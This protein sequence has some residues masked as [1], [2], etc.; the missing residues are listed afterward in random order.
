MASSMLLFFLASLLVNVTASLPPDYT[1]VS[2][3]VVVIGGGSS[4][5]YAAVNLLAH[6]R[7]VAVL[8]Q[9]GRL[10]GHVE[11][12]IDPAT[13]APSNIGV[14]DFYNNSIN[15]AYFSLLGVP[16]APVP[17]TATGEVYLDLATGETVPKFDAEAQIDSFLPAVLAYAAYVN[18]TY[19]YLTLSYENLSYPIPDELLEPFTVFAARHNFTAMLQFYESLTQNIG[20]LWQ[21]PTYHGIHALDPKLVEFTFVGFINA[22]SGNNQ[23]I[24]TAAATYLGAQNVFLNSTVLGVDRS[25]G[26]FGLEEGG[27]DTSDVCVLSTSPSSS[28]NQTTL[29]KARKLLVAIPPT[30]ASLAS[31]HIDLD[32]QER[33]VFSKFHG[34][35]YGVTV[36]AHPGLNTSNTYTNI[37]A[38]TPDNLP[39]LPGAFSYQP[40]PSAPG[41][42]AAWFGALAE[43]GWTDAD[44]EGLIRGEIAR[45][46]AN[47][48]AAGDPADVVFDFLKIH[49]PF[50][51]SA[52]PHDVADGF[53]KELYALE[54]RRNTFWTGAAWSEQDSSQIWWWSELSLL[55]KIEAALN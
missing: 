2:R 29:V 45:L 37:G 11:T 28:G 9:Q 31:A 38:Q 51:L 43:S 8:E 7:T 53:Y 14:I 39:S 54:G 35:T 23:D 26:C 19:P 22:A 32:A 5:T 33:A 46:I 30:L 25:G 20:N 48:N 16:T 13:G 15:Q 24:Y 4:G 6:G 12:Y 27:S 18:A 44:V 50:R 55:P 42:L 41:R 47:G 34:F 21:L 52:R 17:Q 1:T 10:G 36:F 49:A 3:D 40:L